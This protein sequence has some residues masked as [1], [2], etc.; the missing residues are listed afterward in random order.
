[1]NKV[2]EKTDIFHRLERYK[3]MQAPMRA[4]IA[5]GDLEDSVIGIRM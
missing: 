2:P 1:M 3:N 4:L 5:C